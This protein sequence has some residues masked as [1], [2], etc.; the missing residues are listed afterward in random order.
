MPRERS[1]HRAQVHRHLSA[2]DEQRLPVHIELCLRRGREVLLLEVPSDDGA[3]WRCRPPTEPPRSPSIR[4]RGRRTVALRAATLRSSS[5]SWLRQEK[6]CRKVRNDW[7]YA[8]SISPIS[9]Q[10]AP[11]LAVWPPRRRPRSSSLRISMS[12][13]AQA[14]VLGEEGLC[15]VAGGDRVHPWIWPGP[16][17]SRPSWAAWTRFGC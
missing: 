13:V 1:F 12:C 4:G 8:C 7:T 6:S 16:S 2:E 10:S 14:L 3:A 9:R 5:G 11:R 17:R 15:Q